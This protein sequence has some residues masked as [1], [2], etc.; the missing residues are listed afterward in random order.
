MK[1]KAVIFLFFVVWLGLSVDK[2]QFSDD[3][4][5]FWV[6]APHPTVAFV[7]KIESTRAPLWFSNKKY[8][9]LCDTTNG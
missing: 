1:P 8:L 9:Y 2:V 7:Q 5:S 6:L 4:T 3:H